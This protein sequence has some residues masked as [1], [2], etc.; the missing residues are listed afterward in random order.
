[1]I[2]K[3]LHLSRSSRLCLE[4]EFCHANLSRQVAVLIQ[5]PLERQKWRIED[6]TAA[7]RTIHNAFSQNSSSLNI[8]ILTEEDERLP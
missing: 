1:M 3:I 4:I 8:L 2:V 5:L 6:S 7:F